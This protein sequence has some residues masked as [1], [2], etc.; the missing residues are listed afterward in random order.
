MPIGSSPARTLAGPPVRPRSKATYP[1][2]RNEFRRS[3]QSNHPADEENRTRN[4]GSSTI[5]ID[6]KHRSLDR[7]SLR[8]CPTRLQY[9]HDDDDDDDHTERIHAERVT[10]TPA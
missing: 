8:N 9:D 2:A 7:V 10:E 4:P 1:S 5:P 6:A 3:V